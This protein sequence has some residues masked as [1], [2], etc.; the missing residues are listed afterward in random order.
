MLYLS[1]CTISDQ[2]YGQGAKSCIEAQVYCDDEEDG[3]VTVT[4]FNGTYVIYASV[5]YFATI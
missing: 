5:C 1:H 4:W 2:G 3:T